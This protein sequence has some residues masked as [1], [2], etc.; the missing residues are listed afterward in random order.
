MYPSVKTMPSLLFIL[1]AQAGLSFLR[2]NM[3]TYICYISN[4]K[5]CLRRHLFSERRQGRGQPGPVPATVEPPSGGAGDPA[6]QPAPVARHLRRV[7]HRQAQHPHG[8]DR[9]LDRRLRGLLVALVRGARLSRDLLPN[10]LLNKIINYYFLRALVICHELNYSNSY[11]FSFYLS[12]P[13]G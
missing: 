10:D 6:G 9:P 11:L 2:Q 13:V 1:R 12:I 8:L 3:I 7:L 4:L 5:L